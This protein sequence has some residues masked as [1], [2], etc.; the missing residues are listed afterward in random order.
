MRL[1][2]FSGYGLRVLI[3]TGLKGDELSTIAE[4]AEAYQ[5]SKNHLMKVVQQLVNEGFLYSRRGK[6]GGVRL[7]REPDQISVGAVVLAMEPG[8]GV[9]ECMREGNSCT[10]TPACRLRAKLQE[11]N[12]AFM[13]VLD[14][15]TIADVLHDSTHQDA[16][17]GL[18]QLDDSEDP[19][20]PDA[21]CARAVSA[22][23]GETRARQ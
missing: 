7:A 11:A 18:L 5:I 12:R 10:L 16:L 20:G 8:F 14:A 13:Q 17:R 23:F 15:V 22:A 6:R 1:T 9:A 21:A 3:Y 2:Q 4:I 19:L